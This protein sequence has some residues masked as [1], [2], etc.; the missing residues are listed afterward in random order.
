MVYGGIGRAARNWQC[1]D[2]ILA[3]SAP[4]GGRD[5]AG[6]IGQARRRFQDAYGCPPG[7]DRELEPGPRWATWENFNE[8]DR[9]GLMMFGQMTAGSWIY[10]GSQGIIQGTY[11][12]FAEVGRKHYGGSMAGR[13][14]LTAGLGGMGAAQ[15]LAATFA[16]AA[17]LTIECQQSRI[18]FRLRTRYL[19]SQAEN[20]DDALARM[21]HPL[22]AP[23][24]VSV[25]LLGNA[26]EIVPEMRDAGGIRPDPVRIR[27]PRTIRS[28]A[29]C[30]AAGRVEQWKERRASRP[31]QHAGRAHRL[32]NPAHVR[33]ILD[34]HEMG[35]PSVDY[36]NNIRQV[37]LDEGVNEFIRIIPVSCRPIFVR[38]SARASVPFD[39]WRCPAI[40]RTS[41]APT[42]KLKSCSRR[43]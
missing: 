8:L 23:G 4:G 28:M 18:A 42:R 7:T 43:M 36:G 31:V 32:H 38:C 16:G 25:G 11:E 27:P 17:P 6:S 13:W 41:T 2:Q 22:R 33:A 10:I 14:I 9:K 3:R 34:F 26:C 5:A 39:G 19:D 21:Q 24:A 20:L 37:A 30:R 35:V 40:P 12:T 1:F 29:I 15:P